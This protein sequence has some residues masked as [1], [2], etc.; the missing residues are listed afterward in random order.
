MTTLQMEQNKFSMIYNTPKTTKLTLTSNID[1]NFTQ[2]LSN[3][4]K[5]SVPIKNVSVLSLQKIKEDEHKWIEEIK[6]EINPSSLCLTM[7]YDSYDNQLNRDQ[8]G[9]LMCGEVWLI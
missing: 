2:N 3:E 8:Y 1:F 4:Q 5:S 6:Q 9:L 7:D